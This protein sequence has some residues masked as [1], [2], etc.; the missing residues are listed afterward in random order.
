[1]QALEKFDIRNFSDHLTPAR[2]KNRYICPVCGGN[3][4]TIGSKDGAYKCWSGE[5][6]SKLIRDVIAPLPELQPKKIRPKRTRYFEY[7]AYDANFQLSRKIRVVRK[8][9]GEGTKR[10][11]QEHWNGKAWEKGLGGI[12]LE[13]VAPYR[14]PEVLKAIEQ[15]QPIFV[16]E[17]EPVADL[18]WDLDIP[19]TT[20][21]G[22]SGKPFPVSQLSEAKKIVLCPDRD[23]PGLKHML[24]ISTAMAD[25]NV[26]WCLAFPDSPLWNRLSESG[27]LDILDWVEEQNLDTQDILNATM[28]HSQFTEKLQQPTAA[29]VELKA[30]NQK[31]SI[32]EI[33]AKAEEILKARFN[34]QLDSIEAN[35]LLEEL[36]REA[37]LNDYNWEQKYLKPLREKLERSLALPIGANQPSVPTD[38]TERRRLELLALSQE[39]DPDKF[40][41][42]RIAFCRRY[43]WSRQEVE[44]RLRHL[45]TSTTTPK[46]KRLKGK[47]F[48]SLETESISWVFPGIIP[49][50]GVVVLGGHAGA[51]KTTLAYDAVGSLLLGEEFLGEKPVKA[52]KVLVVTGDELPCFT[53]D[54]LIDRGIPLGNEDWE[55]ILNW[56]V[57]QWDVL[58]EVLADLR[59]TLVV[60][61]SFSSIHRDSS[62]DENSSQ[63]KSTI[64]DLEAL[65]NAYNCGCILIHH[66]S[67]SKENQG[68]AKLR[69]S[70]A[71]AAAASVVCL[72]EQTSDG[73]RRLS[74]PKVRGA[75]TDPFLAHL[76]GSTGRYEVVSGGDDIGTKSLGDRI[77]AFLQKEPYKRFEQDE[78]SAALGIPSSHKDS[79]Y[80]ALGRLFKRGLI[81]KRPSQLGGKRKVY[82]VTNPSQLSQAEGLRSVTDT[83]QDTHPPLPAKVSVQNAEIVTKQELEVTDT[84]TDNLTNSK[85]THQNDIQLVSASNQELESV[86]A[87]LTNTDS[88]GCVCP[89]AVETV[90]HATTDLVIAPLGEEPLQQTGLPITRRSDGGFEVESPSWLDTENLQSMAELLAECED[91][92]QYDLLRQCWNPQGI[93]PACITADCKF[94]VANNLISHQKYDQLTQWEL[95]L[96]EPNHD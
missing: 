62:F 11:W 50:R 78:I 13:D 29:I 87:K 72:M 67:K 96:I 39:R 63:A 15:G 4:L 75:Q 42:D 59:P 60:I 22:G 71:I 93:T 94:G 88:Q 57:S 38:R 19:A 17:G 81:T 53:Q 37:G 33:V 95:N 35:I 45:K 5:C 27:G 6:E 54:K 82:G 8:D 7:L 55:I 14:Y 83:S 10:I 69:G 23:K 34:S 70:S 90:T 18:L 92:E 47:D 2:G 28:D 79:V 74:F 30:S 84:L 44:Q 86:S 66:L 51:G 61:D 41:D 64:Y 85:L 73:S 1:M 46:A 12:K 31:P 48:L 43:G 76:D 49:S 56:D 52:G 20:N 3:N 26:R 91:A 21:I 36:R 77:L 89:P 16:V 65:T 25:K 68:V 9:D 40:I 32:R 58:E 24:K 80:Q